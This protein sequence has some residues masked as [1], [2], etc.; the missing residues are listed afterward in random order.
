MRSELNTKKLLEIIELVSPNSYYEVLSDIREFEYIEKKCIEELYKLT[1]LFTL[2]SIRSK[3]M[4]EPIYAE[5]ISIFKELKVAFDGYSEDTT[6][7]SRSYVT[8]IH[9]NAYE[10]GFIFPEHEFIEKLTDESPIRKAKAATATLSQ[11]NLRFPHFRGPAMSV[12][13]SLIKGCSRFVVGV[14]S[15][16][17]FELLNSFSHSYDFFF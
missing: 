3:G 17:S 5:N 12:I 14:L 4:Q 2:Y 9:K 1:E 11:D 13:I 6:Q 15:D 7:N 10:D 8:Y 16:G